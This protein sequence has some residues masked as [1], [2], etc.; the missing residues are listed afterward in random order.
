MGD[1]KIGQEWADNDRR[2]KGRRI[3]VMAIE[4]DRALV[5]VDRVA[6]GQNKKGVGKRSHIKLSRFR[7]GSTG[8][9]L[10]NDVA[11][12]P[13]KPAPAAVAEPPKVDAE[14]TA[15]GEVLGHA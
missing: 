1:V 5:E 11:D 10:V 8:Y 13:P 14:T 12:V 9:T 15:Q 3:L 6:R 2:A 4:G 7:P